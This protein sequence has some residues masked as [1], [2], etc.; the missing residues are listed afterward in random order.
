M[1]ENTIETGLFVNT[2]GQTQ[3][4]YI[5]PVTYAANISH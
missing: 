1:E 2:L 3:N 5:P 4:G